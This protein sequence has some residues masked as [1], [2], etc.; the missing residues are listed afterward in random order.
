MH[1][2]CPFSCLFLF[3]GVSLRYNP[4]AQ[5]YNRYLAW[6]TAKEFEK[7]GREIT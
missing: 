5:C 4:V 6:K 2:P 1:L 3:Y 7:V